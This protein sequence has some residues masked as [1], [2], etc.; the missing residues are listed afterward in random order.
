MTDQ[1]NPTQIAKAAQQMNSDPLCRALYGKFDMVDRAALMQS[2]ADASTK[3]S[4]Q[5]HELFMDGHYGG[6][7]DPPQHGKILNLNKK[8]PGGAIEILTDVYNSDGKLVGT[9]CDGDQIPSS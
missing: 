2:V 5:A 4:Q 1:F 3:L 7:I 8:L 9:T 6:A